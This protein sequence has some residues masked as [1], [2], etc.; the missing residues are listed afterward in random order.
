MSANAASALIVSANGARAMSAMQVAST[1]ISMTATVASCRADDIQIV[2][3]NASKTNTLMQSEPS[4]AAAYFC[5]AGRK[6]INIER[7]SK[8]E[9]KNE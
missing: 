9:I 6:K 8:I 5:I 4:V 7:K 1:R 3:A 2:D